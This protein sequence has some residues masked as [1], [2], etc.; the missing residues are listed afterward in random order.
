MFSRN[1][2]NLN[3]IT[4]QILSLYS[5]N[6][7]AMMILKSV[8]M[9]DSE[10]VQTLISFHNAYPVLRTLSRPIIHYTQCKF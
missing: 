2:I 5:L 3:Y 9:W 10:L 7:G 8:G 1:S 6:A 4:T